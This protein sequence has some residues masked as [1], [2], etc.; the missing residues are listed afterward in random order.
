MEQYMGKLSWDRNTAEFSSL[1][2]KGWDLD[3]IILLSKTET[4]AGL[5][6][7]DPKSGIS[8]NRNK[9][10]QFRNS[11]V[12]IS[13]WLKKRYHQWH[14]INNLIIYLPFEAGT[15]TPNQPECPYPGWD[16]VRRPMRRVTSL[17]CVLVLCQA[18]STAC[19][20]QC[21]EKV[22]YKE[23]CPGKMNIIF[24]HKNDHFSPSPSE[25]FLPMLPAGLRHVKEPTSEPSYN[26]P[27]NS[28][29]F[30]E[31][32]QHQ[33]LYKWWILTIPNP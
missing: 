33:V 32:S 24:H 17:H 26:T 30:S 22:S 21:C 10:S 6:Q 7:F 13:S 18:H 28:S 16:G 5:S 3:T 2:L 27:L 19:N 15:Q 31:T 4:S 11:D 12:L 9:T 1:L 25:Y 23:M 20:F 29:C 8:T 14:L